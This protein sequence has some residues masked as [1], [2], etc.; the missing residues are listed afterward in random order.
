MSEAQWLSA[1]SAGRL[2]RCPASAAFT[3]V[4]VVPSASTPRNAGSLAHFA[5]G[6]WLE[7]GAWL[8]DNPGA[9]LQ[10]AW[11]AEASRWSIDAKGLDDSVITRSRLRRRGAELASFLRTSGSNALSEAVLQDDHRRIYGQL[12]V[13][14]NGSDGGAVVDLKTG[15]IGN[16]TISDDVR[17]QLLLYAHLFAQRYG[18]LPTSLV[19]FSLRYGGVRVE[20]SQSDINALLAFIE[21]ARGTRPPP[22]I[23]NKTGCKYCRRRLTCAPHWEAAEM[24]ADPDCVEG[25]IVK[26]ETSRVGLTAIRIATSRGEEWITGLAALGDGTIGVG[27]S[28]RVAEVTRRGDGAE[29]EWRATRSTRVSPVG[30]RT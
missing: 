7:S 27:S 1:T 23:P 13:V 20:F 8:A 24:W 22:A 10:A 26:V 25:S 14:V 2:L 6:A 4:P 29:S 28:I 15:D 11:D 9:S 3:P 30:S 16:G 18:Q 5:M 19:A 12:D 21:L 17:T